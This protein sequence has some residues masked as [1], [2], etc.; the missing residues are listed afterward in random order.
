MYLKHNKGWRFCGRLQK[1]C[2]NAKS[3]SFIRTLKYE[4]IHMNEYET[5]GEE[6]ASV[7]NFIDSVYNQ[8][9][10][11]SAIGYPPPVEFER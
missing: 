11:H 2:D 3:E 6:R 10:L 1:P 8:K 5:L 4:E 7:S 9:R